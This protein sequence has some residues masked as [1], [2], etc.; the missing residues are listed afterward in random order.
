MSGSISITSTAMNSN[1]QG[2]TG[3]P[4]VQIQGLAVSN[5]YIEHNQYH[6]VVIQGGKDLSFSNNFIC[7][8]SS[9]AT[10]A[11]V[12]GFAFDNGTGLIFTG[13]TVGQCGVLASTNNQSFGVYIGG[14]TNQIMV[15]NNRL[16]GNVS[17]SMSKVTGNPS[18]IMNDA[19]NPAW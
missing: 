11:S 8:N 12:P 15:V 1:Y 14:N 17:G 13:N 5:S 9:T 10:N 3:D 16:P 18:V 7:K 4:G 2:I 19:D 6:G